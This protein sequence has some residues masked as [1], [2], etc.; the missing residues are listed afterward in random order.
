M[1]GITGH[2]QSTP[3][4]YIVR[5]FLQKMPVSPPLFNALSM[6]GTGCQP[7]NVTWWLLLFA[8]LVNHMFT[9]C[10]AGVIDG[11]GARALR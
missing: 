7:S 6:T 5:Y 1:P 4:Q 11:R 9:N 3:R 10:T 2:G 8:F